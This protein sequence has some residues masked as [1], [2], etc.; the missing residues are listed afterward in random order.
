MPR[1]RSHVS[2]AEILRCIDY[3]LQLNDYAI[4]LRELG[5]AVGLSSS[6]TIHAR[7]ARL[8]KEGLVKYEPTDPRTLRVT[9]TARLTGALE[10][11]N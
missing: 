10:V 11:V 6:S 3:F 9:E 8:A 4:S 2:D 7:I 5:E 1:T